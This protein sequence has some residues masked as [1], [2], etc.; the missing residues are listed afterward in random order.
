MHQSSLKLAET[1]WHVFAFFVLPSIP[2]LLHGGKQQEL[3]KSQKAEYVH[4][5]FPSPSLLTG[6]STP[7]LQSF[8][9][10]YVV[11]C[12]LCQV[13]PTFMYL[14]EKKS[15][16]KPQ[17]RY[18]ENRKLFSA[19]VAECLASH[20]SCSNGFKHVY[21]CD[22]LWKLKM[23]VG[24]YC[25]TSNV[26]KAELWLSWLKCR[27]KKRQVKEMSRRRWERNGRGRGRKEQTDSWNPTAALKLKSITVLP[28]AWLS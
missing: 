2:K 3:P 22:L 20:N 17:S 7:C 8:C 10:S 24:K 14:K 21:E 15:R 13:L 23:F 4:F 25:V 6:R 12:R 5:Y 18:T 1:E 28:Y 9:S 11:Y 16:Y 27:L 26:I 19:F